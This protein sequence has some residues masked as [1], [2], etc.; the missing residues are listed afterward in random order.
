MSS[1]SIET[2]PIP[3]PNKRVD[4]D[5]PPP[6]Y[7]PGK[8]RA[9]SVKSPPPSIMEES[10]DDGD[11]QQQRVLNKFT[12]Y[13]T[14]TVGLKHRSYTV[15]AFFP[16]HASSPSLPMRPPISSALLYRGLESV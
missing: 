1:A 16:Q 5:A 3:T 8:I 2:L 10:L 11:L 9:K 12:L 7:T 6:P 15:F 14:K 4:V 13:E